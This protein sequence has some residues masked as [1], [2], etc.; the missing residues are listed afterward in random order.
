MTRSWSAVSVLDLDLTGNG[1]VTADLLNV[2]R[3]LLFNLQVLSTPGSAWTVTV[4]ASMDG[5]NWVTLATSAGFVISQATPARYLSLAGTVAPGYTGSLSLELQYAARG[6]WSDPGTSLSSQSVSSV[7]A[8]AVTDY[9][10][11]MSDHA[12]QFNYS[13]PPGNDE[14][15]TT[16]ELEG[17]LDGS[18]WYGMATGPNN[19]TG[20]GA[21]WITA[22]DY[23]ARYAR[24]AAGI[25]PGPM[26][27]TALVAASE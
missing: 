7:T 14:F 12:A 21:F 18:V 27:V 17:S 9:G 11:I 3:D 2:R 19:S 5:S 23:P 1:S 4:Q 20:T 10:Q 8:G 25:G 22:L 13:I 26:T 24:A 16:F 6:R 15:G